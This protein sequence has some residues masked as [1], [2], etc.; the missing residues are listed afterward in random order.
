[1]VGGG[2]GPGGATLSPGPY[3]NNLRPPSFAWRTSRR[4]L[5][6]GGRGCVPPLLTS[7]FRGYVIAPPRRRRRP[8][9]VAVPPSC[10]SG[11][12][13]IRYRA[14]PWAPVPAN[15]LDH[16]WAAPQQRRRRPPGPRGTHREPV[17]GSS[18]RGST[19][20]W[21]W[22]ERAC[23]RTGRGRGTLRSGDQPLTSPARHRCSGSGSCGQQ[24]WS[25]R[26][27]VWSCR[28]Q[29]RSCR[30]QVWS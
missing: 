26:Q 21:A 14:I 15:F 17:P 2:G 13:C 18:R 3:R 30:Q 19:A 5:V 11:L 23:S 1:V 16:L 25:C 22:C 10:G 4:S 7:H 6:G 9:R 28:Q 12:P 20:A 24:V 29:V 27:Q 8:L